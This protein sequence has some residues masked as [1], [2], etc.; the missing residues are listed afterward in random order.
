MKSATFIPI[1]ACFCVLV[2]AAPG[3][4]AKGGSPG[5]H[6]FLHQEAAPFAPHP[7]R[8]CG[9]FAWTRQHRFV[10]AACLSQ[11]HHARYFA[12]L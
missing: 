12:M 10:R 2:F 1:A 8:Q 6:S 4:N 5:F 3:A 9:A 7:S 11:V